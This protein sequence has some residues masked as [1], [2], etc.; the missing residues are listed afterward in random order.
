MEE[1]CPSSDSQ[2]EMKYIDDAI[3]ENNHFITILPDSSA[4][5]I[6]IN[7]VIIAVSRI[8]LQRMSANFTDGGQIIILVPINYLVH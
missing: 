6:I 2:P 1:A 8:N 7:V 5:L 4:S 3:T